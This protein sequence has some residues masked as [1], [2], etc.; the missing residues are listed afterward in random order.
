MT[1]RIIRPITT[2]GKITLPKELRIKFGFVDYVEIIDI[3][4][5]VLIKPLNV[6]PEYIKKLEKIKKQKGIIGKDAQDLE[7][8]TWD[9]LIQTNT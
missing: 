9:H 5:G 4:T 7:K 2:D 1:E 8:I 3:E 6:N